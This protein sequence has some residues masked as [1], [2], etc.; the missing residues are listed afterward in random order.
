MIV[1]LIQ[2]LTKLSNLAL[3]VQHTTDALAQAFGCGTQMGFQNLTYVHARRHTQRVQNDVNGVAELVI[4]HIFN[5]LDRRNYTL[6]TVTTRHLVT[7]LDAALDSRVPVS[8]TH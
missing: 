3:L 6:V 4:R 1:N 5:R 8:Y 7:W 2:Q